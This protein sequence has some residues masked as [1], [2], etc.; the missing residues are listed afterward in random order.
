MAERAQKPEDSGKCCLLDHSSCGWLPLQG[1]HK[2]A[3]MGSG[4]SIPPALI[5]LSGSQPPPKDM[6]VEG[7]M[8]RGIWGSG[9]GNWASIWSSYIRHSYQTV[10]ELIKDIFFK[11]QDNKSKK[12]WTLTSGLY[13]HRNGPSHH[14]H[15][16]WVLDIIHN[17]F[18]FCSH[19]ATFEGVS[20]LIQTTQLQASA[21]LFFYIILGGLILMSH[22]LF[23]WDA[24]FNPLL[25]RQN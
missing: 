23:P 24:F 2:I 3:P 6:K 10:K 8:S 18:I 14:T 9:K 15:I 16:Q 11:K 7:D 5:R 22:P 13:R 19:Q 4:S 20:P 12:H 17:P 21:L 25:C 1:L